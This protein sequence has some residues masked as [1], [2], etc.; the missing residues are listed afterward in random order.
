MAPQMLLEPDSGP[1]EGGTVARA[2]LEGVMERW[3]PD[4][5]LPHDTHL[6]VVFCTRLR[7]MPV[8]ARLEKKPRPMAGSPDGSAVCTF[9]TPNWGRQEYVTIELQVNKAVAGVAGFLF[10]SQP[11]IMYARPHFVMASEGTCVTLKGTGLPSPGG[12]SVRAGTSAT[13]SV[14][15]TATI[16][17]LSCSRGELLQEVET[18]DFGQDC[19]TMQVGKVAMTGEAFFEISLNGIDFDD[20]FRRW[21]EVHE[22]THARTNARTHANTHARTHARTHAHAHQ[23]QL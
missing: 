21:Q 4:M 8:R 17:M 16:R 22:P 14:P 19:L 18:Q 15:Q 6:V 3:G 7:R 20:T 12:L 23:M 10:W 13:K 9:T 11:R 5:L 2:S 1:Q